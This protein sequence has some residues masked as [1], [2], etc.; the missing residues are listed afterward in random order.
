MTDRQ[1]AFLAA[2]LGESRR[3]ATHAATTAGYAWPDKQGGR[4]T[5]FPEIAAVIPGR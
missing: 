4:L 1:R 3:N 5:T 2:Y